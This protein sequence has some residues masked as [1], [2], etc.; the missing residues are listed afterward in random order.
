MLYLF[1]KDHVLSLLSARNK[2]NHPHYFAER[3]PAIQKAATV[4]TLALHILQR[5]FLVCVLTGFKI[6]P[7]VGIVWCLRLNVDH[8]KIIRGFIHGLA[9]G[10][11]AMLDEAQENGIEL[12][13][14]FIDT[15][16][17]YCLGERVWPAELA[18]L[19]ENA[20]AAH[21]AKKGL[22]A[23]RWKWVETD[24]AEAH[25]LA[26]EIPEIGSFFDEEDVA[27]QSL[28]NGVPRKGDSLADDHSPMTGRSRGTLW[29]RVNMQVGCA[30]HIAIAKA[31][32]KYNGDDPLVFLRYFEAELRQL[33][34]DGIAYVKAG[35]GPLYALVNAT[36]TDPEY[37]PLVNA[38][39]R[40]RD[41]DL[42]A[43]ST[44]MKEGRLLP[45]FQEV[46]TYVQARDMDDLEF[47]EHL[48]YG[49]KDPR[50]RKGSLPVI[51]NVA[52]DVA[53][54]A[55]DED[56]DFEEDLLE[57]YLPARDDE[58]EEG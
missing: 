55:A 2:R 41:R 48:A 37:G 56:A 18:R 29:G 51:E 8:L 39:V 5:S 35:P 1:F 6:T 54:P 53:L 47:A 19:Y 11:V 10:Y 24:H 20:F 30:E 34:K 14:D 33:L 7:A 42:T 28:V 26:R 22:S 46:R 27:A 57:E 9:N 32:T 52:E 25:N 3:D 38:Y 12:D 15:V 45:V 49:P 44:S 21:Q 43:I 40:H 50:R 23:A 58:E 31:R 17:R 4:L 36:L 13:D 16:V